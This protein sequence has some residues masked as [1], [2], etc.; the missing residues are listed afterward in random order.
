MQSRNTWMRYYRYS[1]FSEVFFIALSRAT[2]ARLRRWP[3]IKNLI[4]RL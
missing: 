4:H 2:S 1:S 3:A